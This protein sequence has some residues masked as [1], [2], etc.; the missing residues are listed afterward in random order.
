[1]FAD[2][3][4][5]ITSVLSHF[6]RADADLHDLIQQ[7]QPIGCGVSGYVTRVVHK[8]TGHWYALKYIPFWETTIPEIE[9]ELQAFQRIDSKYVPVFY[10]AYYDDGYVLLL[11]ELCDYGSLFDVVVFPNRTMPE[12]V[13]ACV[14]RQILLGL[15]YLHEEAHYMHRDIKPQNLLVH[16]D[17]SIKITDFGIS[18]PMKGGRSPSEAGDSLHHYGFVG[19]QAYMSPERLVNKSYG[20]NA[21]VWGLGVTLYEL[22]VG[23]HPFADYVTQMDLTCAV[24][25]EH[26]TPHLPV[27]Q[28]S[29]F[30]P[31][32]AEFIELCTKSNPLERAT[33]SQLL[34]HE[35]VRFASDQHVIVDYLAA[36]GDLW[37]PSRSRS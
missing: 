36:C 11:L 37:R 24:V 8:D 30:S 4:S 25:D 23:R 10:N 15:Q 17:G 7:G 13:L 5:S 20:P 29:G 19:T 32:F 21:D 31:L 6:R 12:S 33:A 3:D 9:A 16:S 28:D 26:L 27:Q 2:A 1:M 35:W 14:A 34:E 18:T 22:A